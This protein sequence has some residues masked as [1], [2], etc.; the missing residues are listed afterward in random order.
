LRESD[1]IERELDALDVPP[2]ERVLHLRAGQEEA[3]DLHRE[4]GRGDVLDALLRVVEVARLALLELARQALVELERA[5]VVGPRREVPVRVALPAPL[6][7]LEARERVE[8]VVVPLALLPE[9]EHR[10]ELALDALCRAAIV[11]LVPPRA[12]EQEVRACPL[13]VRPR[14]L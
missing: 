12:P 11:A 7:L 14:D 6:V 3:L 2:R 10:A 9:L 1:R 8:R 13:L 5:H 4:R